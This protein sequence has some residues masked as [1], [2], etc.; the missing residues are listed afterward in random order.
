MSDATPRPKPTPPKRPFGVVN[1]DEP[2]SE[3]ELAAASK[4]FLNN[5][6]LVQDPS[7]TVTVQKTTKFVLRPHL[8]ERPLKQHEGL[9]ALR[10]EMDNSTPPKRF[11]QR[12]IK[13]ENK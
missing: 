4:Y 6:A 2:F 11:G 9:L 13:K 3:E 1:L 10:K 7:T 5:E 8:T 12:H